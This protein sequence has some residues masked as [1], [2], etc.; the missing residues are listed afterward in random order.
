MESTGPLSVPEILVRAQKV[1]PQLGIATVY[2]AL[3]LL[4]EAQ[5]IQ[6]VILPSGETRYESADL[7]HHHHFQCRLCRQVFD[8]EA[9]PLQLA[10]TGLPDGFLV[11]NHEITLYGLCAT[12]SAKPAK[13]FPSKPRREKS[14]SR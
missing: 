5:R 11:E 7:G 13:R 14:G 1:Q 9:C 6:T 4:Q 3:K 8:F 10:H 2:R 12:C